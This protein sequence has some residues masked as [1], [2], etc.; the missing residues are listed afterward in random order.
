MKWLR[1]LLRGFAIGAVVGALGVVL[2]LSPV[3]LDFEKNLGLRW[4][5]KIRGPVEP[6]PDVVIVAIDG[7]TGRALDLPR[8][9]RDW[10]RTIHA[11]AIRRIVE[12]GATAVVIDLDFS[13]TKS[14]YE[15]AALAKAI[16]AADRVVLYEPLVGQRQRIADAEGATVGWTWVEE[17]RAPTAQLASAAKAMSAFPLPKLGNA[18]FEFWAFKESGGDAPTTAAIALQLHA[19]AA[20]DQWQQV[21][22]EAG[23]HDVAF[24][25]DP[26][27][28]ER[29][30]K[31]VLEVMKSWR[32][33]VDGRPDL[34]RRLEALTGSR[35]LGSLEEHSL[36]SALV[37]MYG[38]PDSYFL[39]FYGPPGTIPTVPYAAFA[40]SNG[41]DPGA[42]DLEGKVVFLG[43]SDLH[44]PEQPD[45]FYTVFRSD[46]GVD[47]SG[48]EIMA[49]GFANLLTGD[50]IRLLSAQVTA[51]VVLAFGLLVGLVAALL[52]ATVA[53]P[54]V[55]GLAG[56]YAVVAQIAFGDVNLWLPLAT[57]VVV[58]VP[59]ALMAGLMT[60]YLMGRHR[61]RR[62]GDAIS[63]YVPENVRRGLT[64]GTVDHESVNK[65]VYGTCLANDMAGFTAISESKGPKEL[66]RFMNAYFDA[67]AQVLK[68]HD[69][70]V[71]E[72]HA[73]T[74]MCAW[75]AD[76]P[77]ARVRKKAAY[78]AVDVVEEIVAFGH[79][80]GLEGLR[81]RIGLQDGHFYLGH[82]GGGGRMAY[83]ILGDPANTAARLEGLNKH[84]GTTVLAARGVVQGLDDLLVRPVGA[85]VFVGK[86]D[87]IPVVELLARRNA[88]SPE[89]VD[90]CDRFV[91]A[92]ELLDRRAF[93]EAVRAFEQLLED[94]PGDGPSRY[95]LGRARRLEQAEP[96]EDS[97]LVVRMDSK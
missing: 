4:M 82:T 61:E 43:Y 31:R 48:V 1:F 69:V 66:A 75:T 6:P 72:F 95:H 54:V 35:R 88:A 8:L 97:P 44:D 81:P 47:L 55:L 40:G 52:P 2:V 86:G 62:L 73:D 13:R 77:T 87:P 56:A 67:L 18:A 22:A 30:P 46:A 84:L 26:A 9:P 90:L 94:H 63:L 11:E 92:L 24:L 33:A 15:D 79:R 7:L 34:R 85:F 70:D 17:R 25:P 93:G 89:Q 38:G 42:Y 41:T 12:A 37:D 23:A 57:P 71:T 19:H 58:Q 29:D 59:F 91:E 80:E 39:N 27:Q 53:V 96:A 14:A 45:A 49:T 78:A 76:E 10:P 28:I 32:S 36:V 16:S 3:G 68:R 74:I 50:G 5:F 60:Q 83:S 64:E 20:F 21:L 65:V 51:L